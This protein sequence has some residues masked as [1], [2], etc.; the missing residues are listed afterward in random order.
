LFEA[1][2]LSQGKKKEK[3]LDDLFA[4][5]GSLSPPEIGRFFAQGKVVNLLVKEGKI[6]QIGSMLLEV[7]D[8]PQLQKVFF[9]DGAAFALLNGTS[10]EN[11]AFTE[12][13]ASWPIDVLE[14]IFTGRRVKSRLTDNADIF[15]S[16]L[17]NKEDVYVLPY[18]KSPN[19]LGILIDGGCGEKLFNRLDLVGEDAIID[20]F[21]SKDVPKI[22]KPICLETIEWLRKK[23]MKTQVEIFSDVSVVKMFLT[24]KTRPILCAVEEDLKKISDKWGKRVHAAR[25]DASYKVGFST[26]PVFCSNQE[27]GPEFYRKNRKRK[28]PENTL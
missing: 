18:L 25:R 1:F 27:N 22:F 5:L 15:L 28:F 20:L 4:E 23:S 19:F 10:K 14:I 2:F 13:I 11:R 17:D 8:E 26:I 3:L 24:D 6:E 9:A 12:K 7:L 16:S 21:K